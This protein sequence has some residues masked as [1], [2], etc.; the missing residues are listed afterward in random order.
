[1]LA[2]ALLTHQKSRMNKLGADLN[3]AEE[4]LRHLKGEVFMLEEDVIERKRLKSNVFPSV[5]TALVN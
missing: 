1:V 5:C 4:K 3:V 2:V